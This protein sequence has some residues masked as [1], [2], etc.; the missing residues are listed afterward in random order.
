ME[1]E[2]AEALKNSNEYQSCYTVPKENFDFVLENAK[3]LSIASNCPKIWIQPVSNNPYPYYAIIFHMTPE[4]EETISLV[5][6]RPTISEL[7]PY[8]V[9]SVMRIPPNTEV[10]IFS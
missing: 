2:N 6:I 9:V 1:V 10:T 7:K 5:A 8:S 3:G 4:A